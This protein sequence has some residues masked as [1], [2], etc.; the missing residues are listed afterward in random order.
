MLLSFKRMITCKEWK[1]IPWN[2]VQPFVYDL[3]NKIYCHTKKNEIGLVRHCQNKLVK[4]MEAKLLAVRLVSQ[5]NRGKVTAGIDKIAKLNPEPRLKLAR[6]LVLNGKTS[7]IRRVFIPKPNGKL[8]PLGIPTIGDRA[9]Q[10]LVKIVLEPEWEA[11]FETNSYGFRPS[12]STSDAKW[13][14][15]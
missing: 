12:Y 5:D 11:R 13:H 1:Q 14:Q 4:S 10:M 2:K 7:K 8:R 6:K 3:Q 9:K 15:K